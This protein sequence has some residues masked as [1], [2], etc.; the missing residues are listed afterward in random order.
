M[1]LIP[2]L[3]GVRDVV[4]GLAGVRDVANREARRHEVCVSQI[5]GLGCLRDIATTHV[6]H[7]QI[8]SNRVCCF[9]TLDS[10]ASLFRLFRACRSV[11]ELRNG[12]SS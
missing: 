8:L 3:G 12:H 11:L 2:G 4:P 5:Q 9:Q 10:K 6:Y 7:E 1:S